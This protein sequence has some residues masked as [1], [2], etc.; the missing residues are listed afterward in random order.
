MLELSL[1]FI[2]QISM[3]C[4]DALENVLGIGLVL[5]LGWSSAVQLFVQVSKGVIHGAERGDLTEAVLI[6]GVCLV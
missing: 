2:V 6:Q 5:R 3:T 1:K 4:S